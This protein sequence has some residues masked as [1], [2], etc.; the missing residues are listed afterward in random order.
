MVVRRVEQKVHLK[1]GC[2]VAQMAVMMALLTDK[3]MVEWTAA[4]RGKLKDDLMV[5][6]RDE[7]TAVLR[8]SWWADLMAEQRDRLSAVG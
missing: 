8:E 3:V 5:V 6:K 1:A 7:R 2:S 4:Q